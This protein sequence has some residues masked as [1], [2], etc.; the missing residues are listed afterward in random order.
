METKSKNGR[1]FYTKILM[2]SNRPTKF[3]VYTGSPVTLIPKTKFNNITTIRPVTNG[4]HRGKATAG[5]SKQTTINQ[6]NTKASNHWKDG[7]NNGQWIHSGRYTPTTAATTT[8]RRNRIVFKTDIEHPD[9]RRKIGSETDQDPSVLEVSAINWAKYV[10]I[11]SS[12]YIKLGHAPKLD[13]EEPNV[14]DLGNAVRET[15]KQ[16]AKELQLLMTET[17]NDTSLLKTRKRTAR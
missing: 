7:T 15:E 16:F 4:G 3:I 12:H 6:P 14:W 1:P 11:K 13:A 17:I 10:G 8:R 9:G 2:V 5:N